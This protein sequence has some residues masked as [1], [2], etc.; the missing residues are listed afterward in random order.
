MFSSQ[1]YVSFSF[2]NIESQHS[3]SVRH[4]INVL[5]ML[6]LLTAASSRRQWLQLK[7]C[8]NSVFW[9]D[10]KHAGTTPLS[11]ASMWQFS[12]LGL[13]KT[14]GNHTASKSVHGN[15]KLG[16]KTQ[17]LLSEI[18]LNKQHHSTI[19]LKSFHLNRLHFNISSTY[20]KVRSPVHQCT[21][22]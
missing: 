11:R 6:L 10:P 17:M 15:S 7:S 18:R 12:L 2:G 5:P 4:H 9:V 22:A 14:R 8:D 20:K 21:K 13:L 19:H 1:I 3:C 16:T